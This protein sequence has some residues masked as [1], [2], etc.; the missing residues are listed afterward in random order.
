MCDF[1]AVVGFFYM[2]AIFGKIWAV[3]E[4]VSEWRWAGV[5]VVGSYEFD[6]S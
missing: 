6:A 4:V 5:G 3:L 1:G 2:C